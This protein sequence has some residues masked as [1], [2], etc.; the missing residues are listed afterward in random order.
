MLKKAL[1]GL[2]QAPR[3]WYNRIDDHLQDL[4]FV[5]IPSEAAL[6]L[7]LVDAN[8]IIIVVYVDDLLVTGS[9]KKLIKEFKAE[10]LKAFEMKDLVMMSFLLGMKVK[11]DHDGIFIRQKKYAREILKKVHMEDCKSTTSPM[12]QKDK[13]SKDGGADKVDEMHYKNLIGCLMYLT[14]TKPDVLFVVSMFSRFMH[15]ASEVHFQAAK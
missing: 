4:G 14:A 8:L 5:K 10:M 2:K 12:N 11:Q 7:N 9:D 13:F 1:Y 6:Y 3:A 15:Y